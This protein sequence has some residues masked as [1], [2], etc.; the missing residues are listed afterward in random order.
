MQQADSSR[1]QRLLTWSPNTGKWN[2]P[3]LHTHSIEPQSAQEFQALLF[4]QAHSISTNIFNVKN[5][6]TN[7]LT[8]DQSW[9]QTVELSKTQKM[10]HKDHSLKANLS[11][12]NSY[13]KENANSYHHD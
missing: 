3:S 8:L 6:S 11:A 10:N 13:K 1:S 7:T 12:K 5:L 4:R 9:F 2:P